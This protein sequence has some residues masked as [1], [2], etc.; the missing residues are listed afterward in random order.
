[1][2]FVGHNIELIDTKGDITTVHIVATPN[3]TDGAAT[4]PRAAATNGKWNLAITLKSDVTKDNITKVF[5]A[6]DNSTYNAKLYA[7]SI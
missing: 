6:W 3:S 2:S 1:M 5:G 7:F 4:A